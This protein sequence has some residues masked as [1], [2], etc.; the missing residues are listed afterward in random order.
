MFNGIEVDILSLGDADS[1]LVTEWNPQYGLGR[2][3]IDGG[4]GSDAEIVKGFLHSRKFT[5]LWAVVCTHLHNDHAKGL[6][7]VVRDK[8]ISIQN[9]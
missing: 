2:V 1:L 4:K 6:I 5:T 8:T 7:K 9:A 3:L